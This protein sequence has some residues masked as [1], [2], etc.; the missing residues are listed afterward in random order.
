MTA[1]ISSAS[2]KSTTVSASESAMNSVTVLPIAQAARARS[3]PPTAR[4]IATVEPI[5]RPTIMTVSMCITCEPIATAVMS[6]TPRNCPVMKRSA[7]P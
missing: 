1:T 3:P 5:A 7:I 6:A 4:P 2:A